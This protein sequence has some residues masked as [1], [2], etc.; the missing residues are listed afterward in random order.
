V[1]YQ[2][3]ILGYGTSIENVPT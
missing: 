1:L 2:W 3:T